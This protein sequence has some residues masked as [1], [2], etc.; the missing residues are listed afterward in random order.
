M[1]GRFLTQPM[2]KSRYHINLP[3]GCPL[4]NLATVSNDNSYQ[5]LVARHNQ[6]SAFNYFRD[7]IEQYKGWIEQTVFIQSSE[8]NQVVQSLT[9]AS[10]VLKEKNDELFESCIELILRSFVLL[11]LDSPELDFLVSFPRI[12]NLK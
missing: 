9:L 6:V 8:K 5:K 11:R 2:A 4:R 10:K 1:S 12:C 3:T 7:K